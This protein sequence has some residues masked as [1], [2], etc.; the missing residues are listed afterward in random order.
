MNEKGNSNQPGCLRYGL[1]IAF[2]II[3]ILTV[4]IGY[5]IIW[6]HQASVEYYTVAEFSPVPVRSIS[7]EAVARAENKLAE[8]LRGYE[9]GSP[10]SVTL[11]ADDVAALPFAKQFSSDLRER[12]ALSLDG[13]TITAD[14]SFKLRDLSLGFAEVIHGKRLDRYATGKL[15]AEV[16]MVDG[17]PR[18]KLTELSLAG[19][20]LEDMA[21]GGANTWFQGALESLISSDPKLTGRITRVEISENG[22]A[23][24]LRELTSLMPDRA[25]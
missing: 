15:R 9:S 4:G 8:L 24:E 11:S 10:V 20:N 5:F 1:L 14:F 2:S 6:R 19:K 23:S 21:L 18:I 17:A 25:N 22:M 3:V 7:P 16:G 12:L 13:S